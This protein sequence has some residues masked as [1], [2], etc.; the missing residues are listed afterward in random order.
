MKQTLRNCIYLGCIAGLTMLPLSA[1]ENSYSL[2]TAGAGGG[3]SE[4]I[5][6]A[7]GQ[8]DMGWNFRGQA[9]VNLFGGRMGLVGE[10]GFDDMGVTSSVLNNLGFPGGNTYVYS[11]SAEPVIRFGTHHR[12]TP[13]LFGGPGVYH[14]TVDFTA[15]TVATYTGFDPFFGVFYPVAVPANQ[16]LASYSTTKLGV[17]GGAGFDFHLGSSGHG[18]FFAEARYTQ[19]Y[20]TRPM[21]WIPVTF[22]FRW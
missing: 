7:G 10:F 21:A 12:V 19:M 11:F 18:K 2:F 16:V 15:P 14:R 3:F 6:H 8:L 17:T 4:P 20:T 1:Q 9:G 13:Y 5:Y 22:G